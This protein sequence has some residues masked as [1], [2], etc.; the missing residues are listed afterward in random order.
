[1]VRVYTGTATTPSSSV[2]AGATAT[3]LTVTGLGNGTSYRFDV[4]AVNAVGTGPASPL[5]AAVTPRAALAPVPANVTGEAGN[6]SATVRWTPPAS[7]AGI[8]G[9]RV[10]AFVGTTTTVARTVTVGPSLTVAA[11]PGL[12][13]AIA[14]TFQVNAVTA[15]ATGSQQGPSSASS[16]PVTPS[17]TS[18]TVTAPSITGIT[19]GQGSATVAFQPPSELAGTTPTGYRVRAFVAGTATVARTVNVAATATSA[20]VTGLTNGTS[21]QFEVNVVTAAGQGP[22]SARSSSVAPAATVPGAPVIGDPSSG[23]AGGAI[24]ATARWT[25][26]AS[27]GGSPITGYVVTATRYGTAG[28]VLGQTSSP[29]LA[30]STRSYAMTLPAAGSYRFTVVARNAIGTSPPSAA[31]ALVTAR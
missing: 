7:T 19:A 24:T 22:T 3:S 26:P 4:A 11:V 28:Q 21:Y 8:T 16:A 31:S 23:Q 9:Y 2:T 1:V 13:N 18:Q 27:T 30:A 5:T 14:Y 12:L 17:L 15:N 6:A 25:P 20:A 10:R 29:V